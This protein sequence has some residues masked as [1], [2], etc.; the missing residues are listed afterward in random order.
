MG[1]NEKAYSMKDRYFTPL[2][3]KYS[4]RSHPDMH[5]VLVHANIISMIQHADYIN[6]VSEVRLYIIAFL[7]FLSI[8]FFRQDSQEEFIFHCR[9]HPSHS[10]HTI[11]FII[12]TV[13][14]FD[15]STQYKSRICSDYY[16]VILSFELYEFYH[17]RI[18]K[19]N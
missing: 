11:Y 2:N 13:H 12:F 6:E 17:K 15:V 10:N 7:L 19:E 3:E 8:F 5:G 16:S 1:E 14:L 4:G 9:H 18:Q